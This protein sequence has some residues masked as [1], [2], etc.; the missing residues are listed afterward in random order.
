MGYHYDLIREA[1]RKQGLNR[2]AY[3][4]MLAGNS[5][6]DIF[7]ATETEYVI[8]D[9]FCEVSK[10]L[11]ECLHFD[12]IYDMEAADRYWRQLIQN[13]YDAVVYSIQRN[14]PCGFLLAVG[15][16][17]HIL[18]DFYAHS[19][20]A[21][22][23]ISRYTQKKDTTYF[24]ATA[25]PAST[26]IVLGGAIEMDARLP[27][28]RYDY[29]TGL[30]THGSRAT[31]VCEANGKIYT[32][33]TAYNVPRSVHSSL[34]KDHNGKPY[35]PWACRC[36]Y[37]ASLQ[38][39]MLIEKWVKQDLNRPDF[40][41]RV[42]NYSFPGNKDHLYR[43]TNFDD[44]TIRWLC[45]YGGGWKCPRK[46]STGDILMDDLPNVPGIGVTA[47]NFPDYPFLGI[48][49]FENCFNV[50]KNLFESKS[51]NPTTGVHIVR[52]LSPNILN[53]PQA[54]RDK[55]DFGEIVKISLEDVDFSQ[56]PKI[57]TP[58][59]RN[60][61]SYL[62]SCLGDSY[63]Q[64]KW[65]RIELPKVEDMDTGSG[66]FN[67]NNEEIGGTSDYWPMFLINDLPYSEAEYVDSSAPYT[68]WGVLK[69][70]WTS[71][72]LRIHL[73]LY[74]S[75][76]TDHKAIK[77]RI[78][79][80]GDLQ[81][82]FDPV[83][84]GTILDLPSACEWYSIPTGFFIKSQ[85]DDS[86]WGARV[87]LKIG[88]MS[89]RM[90]EF[91]V[92]THNDEGAGTVD[93]VQANIG[94]YVW[95]LD[96]PD[97]DD[98]RP[99]RLRYGL[100]QVYNW[101]K[102]LFTYEKRTDLYTFDPGLSFTKDKL[103]RLVLHK[104]KARNDSWH[105]TRFHARVAD[106]VKGDD[107]SPG[108]IWLNA[109][110]PT[111]TAASGNLPRVALAGE[112]VPLGVGGYLAE[113]VPGGGEITVDTDSVDVYAPLPD[114]PDDPPAQSLRL[115]VAQPKTV[116]MQVGPQLQPREMTIP[117]DRIV[118]SNMQT[119]G[120]S[121]SAELQKMAWYMSVITKTADDSNAETND[122][123][124]ISFLDANRS[125]LARYLLDKFIRK[126]F[127]RGNTDFFWLEMQYNRPGVPFVRP[128]F[129]YRR[130]KY[131]R[132]EKPGSDDWHLDELEVWVNDLL[133]YSGRPN[134]WLNDANRQR[135]IAL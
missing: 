89:D 53:L 52:R 28:R 118:Q 38:W 4:V 70:L 7:Q 49:W 23:D 131:I 60:A 44:G 10:T 111:W 45:T 24:E 29:D 114:E 81:F 103:Y 42:K 5:Y 107:R 34:N 55:N 18:Q 75:D 116:Q 120:F 16:S 22:L 109:A 54:V 133:L 104:D 100:Q 9:D 110:S 87:F 105:V 102:E 58:V 57:D 128:S 56:I 11:V 62:A 21:E 119:A 92:Q 134:F 43:L 99:Q 117:V 82:T 125:V 27:Y 32:K 50:A 17:L 40:W 67:V 86:D 46:W 101:C 26:L 135:E 93:G 72:T 106:V 48:E 66:L 19:N 31:M 88:L 69:P 80:G 47:Q 2:D 112:G 122:P 73:K 64:V 127:Q 98:F 77:M 39:L 61:I 20:W 129:E 71:D 96:H 130:V 36:A 76:P 95:E 91:V 59:V 15:T 41:D 74:E 51:V 78:A 124:Y 3:C 25:N 65:L 68:M 6:V 8:D 123:V 97:Y 90:I 1:A 126:D 132:L 30:F 113:G 14:D 12:Q 108:G 13:T 83:G 35:F 94:S 33:E 37:K 115:L 121:A 85:G 79:P 63:Q 84:A